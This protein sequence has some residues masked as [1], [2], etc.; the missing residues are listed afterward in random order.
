MNL[1]I[2]WSLNAFSWWIRITLLEFDIDKQW[3]CCLGIF[4]IALNNDDG[5][6]FERSLLFINNTT[7]TTRFDLIFL[8]LKEKYK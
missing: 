1:D 6:E 5:R 7:Y 2:T 8:K 4:R 3:G